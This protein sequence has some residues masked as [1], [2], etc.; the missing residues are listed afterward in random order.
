MNYPVRRCAEC[1]K[2]IEVVRE[3]GNPSWIH[4]NDLTET[5]HEIVPMKPSEYRDDEK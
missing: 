1:R 4:T 3:N 5:T 2:Q